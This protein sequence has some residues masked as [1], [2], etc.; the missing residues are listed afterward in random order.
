[1]QRLGTHTVYQQQELS[2][3]ATRSSRVCSGTLFQVSDAVIRVAEP[4]ES[5]TVHAGI[6]EA[7]VHP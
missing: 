7:V 6:G 4:W 1:M 5:S 3:T 2:A